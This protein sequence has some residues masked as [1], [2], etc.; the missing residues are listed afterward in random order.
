MSLGYFII[1]IKLRK[2]IDKTEF[3]GVRFEHCDNKDYIYTIID[4]DND[5][6]EVLWN[7]K[8]VGAGATYSR[9]KIRQL[10]KEGTWIK[11]NN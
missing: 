11:I 7:N 9:T 5:E 3:D 10:F 6:M 4:N 1:M 2:K 8:S